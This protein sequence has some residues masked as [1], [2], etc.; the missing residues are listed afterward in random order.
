[1]K[2]NIVVIGA[3]GHS[4]VI[5]DI[6]EKS[7]NWNI[8]GYLDSFKKELSFFG[9]PILGT[10]KD[11]SF[12]LKDLDIFGG[13]IAI[14]DNWTRFKMVQKIKNISPKFQFISAIHPSAI[15]G[16]GVEIGYG[17][18]IMAGAILNPDA[19]I[20]FHSIINTSSII[21]HD[22]QIGNFSTISP[23]VA[24]GGN[25]KIGDFSTIGIG[26]T[27]KHGVQ[28]SDDVVIGA[29]SVVLNNIQ[30]N[31]IAYGIP[32]KIIRARKRSESYL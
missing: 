7:E 21:E 29:T 19:K 14:G 12:L 17:S 1:M 18:V 20:G 6:L 31:S 2:K 24:M 28:I 25:V 30:Q 15:L 26:A 27:L 16:K 10:E 3:S 5:I 22:S 23:N 13:V 4:K 9:Y 32:A 11:L 8:L